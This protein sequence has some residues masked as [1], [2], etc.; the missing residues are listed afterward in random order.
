REAARQLKAFR[1][2]DAAYRSQLAE[3]LQAAAE[4]QSQP[5]PVADP[6]PPTPRQSDD[7]ALAQQRAQVEAQQ[8]YVQQAAAIQQLSADERACHHELAQISQWLN[9]SYTPSEL[10]SGQ[11][12][13]EERQ[14]WLTEAVHRAAGLQRVAAN[15]AEVRT[16]KQASLTLARQAEVEQW[17]AT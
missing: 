17:S 2:A 11:A 15:A 1:Q 10:R 13:G 3:Q 12:V 16:V 4:A 14:A 6:T 5:E 7:A 8:R 9:S